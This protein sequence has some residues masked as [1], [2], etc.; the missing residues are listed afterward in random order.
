MIPETK[1]DP[2]ATSTRGLL[3]LLDVSTFPVPWPSYIRLHQQADPILETKSCIVSGYFR[4][5]SKFDSSKYE[6]EW[7]ANSLSLHDCM[8]L[9]CEPD[10]VDKIQMHRGDRPTTIL[11]MNLQDLPIAN[12]GYPSSDDALQFWQRQLDIDPERRIHRSYELFWIWLSKSWMVTTAIVLQSYFLKHP[13]DVWMWADIGSFR[14]R[15]FNNVRLVQHAEIVPPSSV[16]FM[17]HRPPN[18]PPTRIWNDKL[19]KEHRKHFFTSGSHAVGVADAWKAF[20]R[21]F[22]DTLYQ[23]GD[24][25]VGEDQ[26]ILQSTCLLHPDLCRYL[27]LDQVPDNKYFGLRHALLNGPKKVAQ[28]DF[29][30]PPPVVQR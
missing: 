2:A 23:F 14:N 15:Q 19:H 12:Y 24:M 11:A 3:E 30:K 10:M 21:S 29:W 8:V 22:A 1:K 5:K 26:C 4:V 20:H 18:P 28:F 17:A 16:L 9:F 25:F 7:M 6:D 13:V 27:P